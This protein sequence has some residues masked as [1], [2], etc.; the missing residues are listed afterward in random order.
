MA[1]N[2]HLVRASPTAV[3][4]VLADPR[5]YAYWVVGSK[6][7]RDADRNWPQRG[8]RFHHTVK[9]GPFRIKD[10]SCV[11]EVQPGRLLQLKVNGRPL[12]TA[13][14]K[15][16]L[17]EADGG[18]QVTMTE[19]PAGALS[20]LVFTSLTHRLVRT[21]NVRSLDRLAELAEGRVAIPGEEPD[22]SVRIS[23][24]DVSVENPVS[25]EHRAT[26]RC[27]AVALGRGA[28]AGIAGAMAMS[29]STNIEMRVRA[30]PPSDA[31]ARALARIFGVSARGKRRRMR[32]ALGGHLAT[33]VAIGAGR[34][35]MGCAGAR[36]APAGAALFGLA[37]LPE[38]VIVPALGA[39]AP[40][41]RWSAVDWAVTCVHHGV[42]AA[43]TTS[44]CALL[45]ARAGRLST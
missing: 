30:R 22:A 35:A 37:L 7:I 27:A 33:S 25:R 26:L 44:A 40:P 39:S 20:R 1:R 10:D 2:E 24:G 36:P 43:T 9:L 42:Y 34:G 17:T 38:I 21:R 4:D 8:S 41:W 12:G 28:V 18:T 15:L 19:D 14:V 13:R 23:H 29:V 3:F 16:E 45:E 11:E 5:G 6:E 32:L 31:P